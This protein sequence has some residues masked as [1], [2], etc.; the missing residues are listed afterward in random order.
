MRLV[1]QAVKGELTAA[2]VDG[3]DTVF[4]LTEGND[5]R[6]HRFSLNRASKSSVRLD[7]FGKL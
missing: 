2:A 3:P 5:Y 6:L 1:A 4:V 7:C